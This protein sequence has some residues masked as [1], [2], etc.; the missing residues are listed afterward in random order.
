[1]EIVPPWTIY[2][3]RREAREQE[4]SYD[5]KVVRLVDRDFYMDDAL[6]SL[7]S[8]TDTIK[9]V[10]QVQEMLATYGYIRQRQIAMTS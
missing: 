1:M 4:Q 5:S 10:G 9:L 6:L 7:S 8:A 3:L 2:R